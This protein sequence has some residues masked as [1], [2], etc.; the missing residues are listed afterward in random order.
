[1]SP[2][3]LNADE[4]QR[5]HDR[6]LDEYDDVTV[7]AV[8]E[9]LSGDRF[10]EHVH[11]AREGYVGSGYVWVVRAPEAAH[12]LSESMPEGAADDGRRALLI[13]GRGGTEPEWGLAGGGLEGYDPDGPPGNGESLETAAV[14]EVREETGIDCAVTDC[15]GIRRV[16]WVHESDE[17]APVSHTIHAFFDGTYEGGEIRIQG[18][19]LNG[20]AWFAELPSTLHPANEVRAESWDWEA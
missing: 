14:R 15:W 16:E 13:L 12:D 2:E 6:L 9:E 11:S 8:T 10:D 7:E 19:E 20:A 5:R 3:P 4:V 17:D 18:G 1:M